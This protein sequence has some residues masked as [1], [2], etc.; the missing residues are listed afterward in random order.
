MVLATHDDR[1]PVPALLAPHRTEVG[2]PAS[3]LWVPNRSPTSCDLGVFVYQPTES[4][5]TS[6]VQVGP[7][8]RAVGVV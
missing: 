7:V 2:E 5:A 6:E 3:T 1:R 8:T 4:V